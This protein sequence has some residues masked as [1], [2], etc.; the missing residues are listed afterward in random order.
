[1]T[2]TAA[3]FINIYDLPPGRRI[4]AATEIQRRTLERNIPAV[5]LRC[6]LLLDSDRNL[7]RMLM[8]R[9][10]GSE[11]QHGPEAS[12]IDALFD[13]V[14][15]GFHDHLFA[16]SR[17]FLGE[18][19]GASAAALRQAVF[20]DGPGAITQL[21]YVQQHAQAE[22]M[23]AHLD[24]P[25]LVTHVAALPELPPMI[26]RVREISAR[27]GAALPPHAQVPSTETIRAARARGHELM[28]EIVAM[29]LAHF[30]TVDP[31]DPEGRAYLLE[32]IM[33][34]NEAMRVTRRRRRRP[35]DID[36]DTGVELPDEP[37]DELPAAPAPEPP[38]TPA[39]ELRA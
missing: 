38:S 32:P 6:A 18:P 34:Q 28:C 35:V 7:L 5:I 31:V 3:S 27:Y 17:I 2:P 39:P 29:I 15:V 21:P 13:H 36:P 24:G 23:L 30:A 9:A 26:T 20:P 37:G 19:R 16:Q 25:E 33:S 14:L 1:M 11:G 22:A 8:L 4:Y 12:E 10:A